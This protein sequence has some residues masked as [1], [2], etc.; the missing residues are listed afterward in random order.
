MSAPLLLFSRAR[1]GVLVASLPLLAQE[2][3]YN[4]PPT[5]AY[6]KPILTS[7]R[8][9]GCRPASSPTVVRNAQRTP[10]VQCSP[11]IAFSWGTLAFSQESG[12]AVLCGVGAARAYPGLLSPASDRF[13][14]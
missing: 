6:E 1:S 10:L 9:G 2:V 7:V 12:T 11:Q 13:V 14:V 3:P 8:Y 5:L 4:E